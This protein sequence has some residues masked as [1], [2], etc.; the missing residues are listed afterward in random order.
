MKDDFR[1]SSKGKSKTEK[2]GTRVITQHKPALP[3]PLPPA[4]KPSFAIPLKPA[5]LNSRHLSS[6][7]GNK[8][9]DNNT[10]PEELKDDK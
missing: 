3:G 4:P 5:A 8:S 2:A 10:V 1:G 7:V 9:S 6:L